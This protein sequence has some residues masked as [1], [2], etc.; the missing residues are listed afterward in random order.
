[1]HGVYAH[2][3]IDDLDLDARSTCFFSLS[4]TLSIV[5]RFVLFGEVGVVETY[6][7]YHIYLIVPVF[8]PKVAQDAT[9]I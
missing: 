3:F 5:K 9:L 7:D 4:N 6:H 8:I 2:V 1:M